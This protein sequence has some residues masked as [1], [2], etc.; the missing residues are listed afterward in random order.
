MLC[1]NFVLYDF[2]T[3]SFVVVILWLLF[4]LAQILL[5]AVTFNCEHIFLGMPPFQRIFYLLLPVVWGS[6]NLGSI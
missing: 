2:I 6:I 5:V 4:S 1:L 3:R